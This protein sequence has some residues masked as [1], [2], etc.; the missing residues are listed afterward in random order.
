MKQKNIIKLVLLLVLYSVFANAKS[1][2]W[3]PIVMGDIITFAPY[4]KTNTLQTL[5]DIYKPNELVSVKVDA[6]LSGDED[7][8]GVYPKNAVSNWANVISWNW[9]PHNGTFALSDIK[10]SM[11]VGAYEARLFFHNNFQ[12]KA[13]YPFTVAVSNFQ[14]TK[15]TYT[16]NETVSVTVNVP[17]SGDKDWV[18]IFHKNADNK[19]SNVLGWQWVTGHGTFDLVRDKKPMPAGEYEARLFWHNAYGADVVA[20][21]TFGFSVTGNNAYVYGS[22]GQYIQEVEW[23][24]NN[25]DY[26]AVYPKNHIRNAPLVLISGYQSLNGYKGLMTFLASHGCYVVAHADRKDSEGWSDPTPRIN[27]FENAIL[28]VENLGVDT[29]RLITMGSSA[30]GM[31]S[32]KIMDYFKKKGYGATKSFIIDIEGYYVPNMT[33]D[34]LSKVESDSLILHLGGYDGVQDGAFDE[35]PRTLLSLS[36]LLNNGMKKSFIVLDSTN[37]GYAAGRYEDVINKKP[38]LIPID[39]MLKY[40]FFNENGQYNDAEAILF[41]KYNETVQ[42]VYDTTMAKVGNNEPLNAGYDYPCVNPYDENGD[43]YD[44]NINPNGRPFEP[45]IDY[46]NDHGLQ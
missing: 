1:I 36:K 25:G 20:K 30:G 44:P 26:F 14:T 7:W 40:E 38:L 33:K 45:T 11:P 13:S 18:G 9:I 42:K 19:W 46:C 28:D 8:V 6:A 17:L 4:V 24:E 43:L 15:A 35:D 3:A 31:V 10:K 27:H 34:D 22:E 21:Q 41:D 16:P 2:N 12:K 39:A 29:S 5:K 32:Y 23:K 37:H